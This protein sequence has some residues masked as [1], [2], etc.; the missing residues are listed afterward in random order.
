MRMKREK[1]RRR[2]W[3]YVRRGVLA[4]GIVISIL[5]VT[6]PFDY[7]LWSVRAVSEENQARALGIPLRAIDV[8][9]SPSIPSRE[10]G[11][12][13]LATLT[14]EERTFLKNLLKDWSSKGFPHPDELKPILEGAKGLFPKLEHI[15]ETSKARFPIDF[16]WH[17]YGIPLDLF[18]YKYVARAIAL[19]AAYHASQG[20]APAFESELRRIDNILSQLNCV[21]SYSARSEMWSVMRFRNTAVLYAVRQ[22]RFRPHIS[23]LKALLDRK[24]MTVDVVNALRG[25]TYY[26]AAALRAGIDHWSIRGCYTPVPT[27]RAP[28]FG[29]PKDLELRGYYARL[30]NESAKVLRQIRRT[31]ITST[32][33][34]E[35]GR[36]NDY[37]GFFKPT[38][39]FCL[40]SLGFTSVGL[41]GFPLE[42]EIMRNVTK[43]FVET[44][45]RQGKTGVFIVPTITGMNP[46]TGKP[47]RTKWTD[48]DLRVII[49]G[50][51][52]RS[53][54]S[55]YTKYAE[56]RKSPS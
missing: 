9:T 42:F 22:P 48:G 32:T 21:P 27:T 52:G 33:Y 19:R 3:V 18:E 30:M 13:R 7:V 17:Y 53:D 6:Y 1:K 2:W 31:G 39:E 23:R 15:S 10:N 45:A 40:L 56:R 43:A 38:D 47:Y 16:D 46:M 11:A 55:F 35:L 25:E 5:L 50:P 34:N 4:L 44:A 8:D 37:Q 49:E 20:A 41:V 26:W 24:S 28:A 29:I 12:M 14:Q 51:F 36:W 54:V